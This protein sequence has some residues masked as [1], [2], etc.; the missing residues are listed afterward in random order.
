MLESPTEAHPSPSQASP[1]D[2]ALDVVEVVKRFGAVTAVSGVSFSVAKGQL[3]SLLGAS[4][5]GK[6][7][8][9]RLIAGIERP[10]GGQI[11]IGGRLASDAQRRVA[12]PPEKR[13]LGMVFQSYALWPHMTV[14]A[15]VEYSLR[16]MRVGGAERRRRVSQALAAVRLDGYERR[17]PGQLSGGQQ[18]RVALARALV[19]EPAV[20]LLD[21]PLSNLDARLREEMRQEI[22]RLHVER[23]LTMLYVTHDQAEALALS[24]KVVLMEAGQVVQ[25]DSPEGL[26]ERPVNA[27]VTLFL[28]ASNALNGRF[29]AEG[30]VRLE[31][32]GIVRCRVALS[33]APESAVIVHCRP[34]GL[35][36]AL[37]G[38]DGLSA[39][40]L[41]A[42]FLGGAYEYAVRLASGEEIVVR[43][44][45]RLADPGQDVRLALDAES[46]HAFAVG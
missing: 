33:C 34:E 43:T 31:A 3:V 13:G 24:D 46:A 6:S 39:E 23:G 40:I 1:P 45:H 4:G 12:L 19:G 29:A 32:G 9:L 7:T 35:R 2:L 17:Y 14:Q 41:R 28:G 42:G 30:F 10:D 44:Q 11:V 20:I 15:N 25:A 8:L 21:E 18:Q 26:Y 38:E 36:Q 16:C 27:S 5:C 22:K 37:P